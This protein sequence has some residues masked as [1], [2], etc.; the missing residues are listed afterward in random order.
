MKHRDRHG[1]GLRGALAAPNPVTGAPMPV[2]HGSRGAELFT[3]CVQAS[4]ARISRSCPR[5]LA[6]VDIGFEDVPMLAATWYDA[7]PLA[8][9]ISARP[10]QRGQVVL[11]RRPIEHRA[12][13]RREL[14]TLVHRTIVEQLSALTGIDTAEIDPPTA[15]DDWD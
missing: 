4:V 9:A 6:G 8:A 5:A 12:A 10:D 11:Y 7:V 13:T 2:R 15:D 14:A 3:T 1:R